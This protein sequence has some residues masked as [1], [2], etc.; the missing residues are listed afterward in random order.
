[1][2]L[3]SYRRAKNALESSFSKRM[4]LLLVSEPTLFAKALRAAIGRLVLLELH[5]ISPHTT[6]DFNTSLRRLDRGAKRLTNAGD[7]FIVTERFGLGG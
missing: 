2:R 5:Y 4:S 6:R 1:M 3:S 7:E